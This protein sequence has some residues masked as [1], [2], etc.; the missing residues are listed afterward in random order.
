MATVKV[1]ASAARRLLEALKEHSDR[2]QAEFLRQGARLTVEEM[3]RKAPV[4]TGALRRSIGV[5]AVEGGR[6]AVSPAVPYWH[7]VERGAKPRGNSPQAGEGS[8]L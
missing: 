2:V 8:C 3:K 5:R 6:V 1:D 7:A 4:R